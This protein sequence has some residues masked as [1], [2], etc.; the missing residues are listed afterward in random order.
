[1]NLNQKETLEDLQL[2]GLKIIQ[3][4]SLYRFTSDAVMLANFV[5]AKPTD[6][7]VDLGTGSGIIAILTAYKNK[8]QNVVGIELQKELA[9]MAERSVEYNKMQNTIKILNFDMQDLLKNKQNQLEDVDIVVCNPPYKKQGSAKLNTNESQKIARHE[10]AVNLETITKVAKSI[11]KFGGKFYIVCDSERTAELIFDL[12]TNK[13]EPKRMFFTQSGENKN[14]ILVFV[15]AVYGGKES[16]KVLPT[17][18]TND[19]DGKYLEKIKKY[20]F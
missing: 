4:P 8:L 6:K 11:L 16:V 20:K 18:I 7:L 2:N 9:Q 15:E 14:A 19:K 13:L 3:S 17:I 1:M 10:V 12:K 5:K